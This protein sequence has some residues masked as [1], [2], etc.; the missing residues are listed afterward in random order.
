[1]SKISVKS[2]LLI[3]AIT[4]FSMPS[5]GQQLMVYKDGVSSDQ[6]T[7]DQSE[8]ATWAAQNTGYNPYGSSSVQTGPGGG[9]IVGNAARGALVG[10]IVGG[11]ANDNAGRGALAGAAGGVL[12]GGMRRNQAARQQQNYQN[13]MQ[14]NY[15]RA[16]ATCLQGRGY[17]VN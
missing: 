13:Q 15:N 6:S 4:V 9:R 14:A 2:I 3:G 17:T 7:R 10:A 8:C 5:Y 11:I 12:I 1:M 16:L